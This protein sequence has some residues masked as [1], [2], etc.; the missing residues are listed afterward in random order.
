[1]SKKKGI[2]KFW[3][4]TGAFQN[5]PVSDGG[6]GSVKQECAL[7]ANDVLSSGASDWE[8]GIDLGLEAPMVMAKEEEDH[9]VQN[10]NEAE[11][12]CEGIMKAATSNISPVQRAWKLCIC[13]KGQVTDRQG[14]ILCTSDCRGALLPDHER[15]DEIL[16]IHRRQTSSH[17]FAD[18]CNARMNDLLGLHETKGNEYADDDDRLANFRHGAKLRRTIPEDYLFGLVAKHITALQD[19]IDRLKKGK[20]MSR[21][22]WLEKTGDV[23]VYTL[24][25]EGL[26]NEHWRNDR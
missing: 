12:A 15:V 1:M 21:E 4:E 20:T 7:E 5:T 14:R 3:Q 2:E 6:A 24:L 22:Q 19:F 25:L 16:S 8:K 23:I 10:M 11:R 26:L 18:Y 9:Y 13:G 17:E